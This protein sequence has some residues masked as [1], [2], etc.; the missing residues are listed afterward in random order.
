MSEREIQAAIAGH[1]ARNASLKQVLAHRKTDLRESHQIE[2]HFWAATKQDAKSLADALRSK[3]F[4]ILAQQ[5]AT[6]PDADLP[7]NI[8]AVVTQ[9]IDLTLR[10]DFTDE[11]VR[12]ADRHNGRYDGWGTAI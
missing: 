6:T 12:L 5:E 10:R 3:G 2:C 8:E 11:L 7:W 4:A 1:E 9:S